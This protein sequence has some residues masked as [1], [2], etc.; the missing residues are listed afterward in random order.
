MLPLVG[1]LIASE[2][3]EPY[4]AF[5]RA[6]ELRRMALPQAIP[7]SCKVFYVA[8]LSQSEEVDEMGAIYAHNVVAM[9]IARQIGV[10]TVNGIASF[11]PP[12]WNFKY[13]NRPDYDARVLDYAAHRDLTGLCRLDLPS[14]R[15]SLASVPVLPSMSDAV[16]TN[17]DPQVVPDQIKSTK[18][19]AARDDWGTWSDD[20]QVRIEFSK[21]LP[22]QV[23]I[24]IVG[25]AF[26]PNVGKTFVAHVG[27]SRVDFTL[28]ATPE[29][30]T[31]VFSNPSRST[32]LTIDIP[33]PT[34][35]KEL[36][37]G[38]DERKLGLGIIQM[39][40]VTQ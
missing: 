32:L 22:A 24:R 17:F 36:E 11:N 27:D 35:P 12:D 13:P 34:S 29:T 30:K 2:I 6:R 28:G 23:K 9:Y 5:D 16:I 19:L 25:H 21:K 7:D 4:L 18:G 3:N 15:W 40:I 37:Q 39:S 26:G 33:K 31:L 14:K 8:G 38:L 1:L 20:D 10:P